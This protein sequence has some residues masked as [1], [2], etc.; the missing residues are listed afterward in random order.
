MDFLKA[1]FPTQDAFFAAYTGELPHGGLFVPTTRPFAVGAP[2]VVDLTCDGL[3]NHVMV[4]ARVHAGRRAIPRKRVRAGVVVA[5]EP[6]EQPKREFVLGVLRGEIQNPARRRYPR[7]PVSVPVRFRTAEVI[8][9]REGEL[10]EISLGGALVRVANPP[11][12]GTRVVLVVQPPRCV[13]PLEIAGV[14]SY[15]PACDRMGVRFLLRD[16]GGADRLREVIRRL[17]EV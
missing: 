12:L 7:I 9:V 14:V 4:R 5:F 11:S 2:V 8:E 16:V 15:A 10:I 1:A 13:H 6:E 3:P 17:C